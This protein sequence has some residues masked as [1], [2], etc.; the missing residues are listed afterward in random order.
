MIA[1]AAR[2]L[3]WPLRLAHPPSAT[4]AV[5]VLGAPLGPGGAL[6]ELLDERV[7]A[8]AALWHAGAAP[9][10]CVTGGG[11]DGRVEADAMAERL[12]ALGVE[13]AAI[14]RERRARST[15][16][17]ARRVAELLRPEGCRSV[18]L[19]SQPFHLRRAALLFA[20]A[21]LDPRCHHIADSLQYRDGRRAL[22]WIAREYA[23]LGAAL[24]GR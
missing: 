2:V 1:A 22:R 10:L 18:W 14:R 12:L 19:V 17:N 7:R 16:E 23:A 24:A 15:A 8:G 6:T 9:L 5:V 11:P 4:D 13:A 20:R 21:G 3:G